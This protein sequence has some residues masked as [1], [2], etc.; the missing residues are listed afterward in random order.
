MTVS[1]SADGIHVQAMM[2]YMEAFYTLAS[3]ASNFFVFWNDI[4]LEYIVLFLVYIVYLPCMRIIICV[5]MT[6][7]LW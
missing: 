2:H 3:A 1:G 5:D 7:K 4:F 6:L